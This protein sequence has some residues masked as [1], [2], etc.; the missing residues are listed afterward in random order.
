MRVEKTPM[1][2]LTSRLL[3]IFLQLLLLFDQG[4]GVENTVTQTF[5]FQLLLTLM[6]LLLFVWPVYDS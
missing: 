3:S 4:T 1:Q 5:A 6:Q 2:T